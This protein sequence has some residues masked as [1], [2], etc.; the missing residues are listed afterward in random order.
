MFARYAYFI[1]HAPAAALLWTARRGF[2]YQ[3][4]RAGEWSSDLAQAD[5][6]EDAAIGVA[7]NGRAE[8]YA[9]AGATFLML[10]LI[11]GDE[12]VAH[13][14][15]IA[16]YDLADAPMLLHELHGGA[17]HFSQIIHVLSQIVLTARSDGEID[18]ASRRWFEVM[19]GSLNEPSI[20]Q[21]VRRAA[22][23]S[24]PTVRASVDERGQQRRSLFL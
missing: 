4:S 14:L 12:R 20:D 15:A 19:G 10:P 8:L 7:Q 22:G 3:N 18:Y 13:V 6:L 11:D 5:L 23:G 17:R 1:D 16:G 24:P 2:T 9:A 21:S